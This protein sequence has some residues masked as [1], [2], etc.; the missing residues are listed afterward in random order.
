MRFILRSESVRQNA[1]KQIMAIDLNKN[2]VFCVSVEEYRQSRNL[3][4]NALLWRIYSEIA[5]AFGT[6]ADFVHEYCKRE[7]L[8]YAETEINGAIVKIGNSTASLKKD[9]FALYVEKVK[10]WAACDLGLS[11]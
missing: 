3:E 9:E 8:G 4:Q 10:A 1:I 5:E 7:F 11:L 6:S 2:P